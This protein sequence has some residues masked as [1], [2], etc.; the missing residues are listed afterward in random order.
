VRVIIPLALF[1]LAALLVSIASDPTTPMA[2]AVV[3]YVLA[4]MLVY[5]GVKIWISYD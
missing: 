5:T 2:S 3:L 1:C 4:G